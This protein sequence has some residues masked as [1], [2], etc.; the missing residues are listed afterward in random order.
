MG[1]SRQATLAEI[2]K[3]YRKLALKYHPDR[4]KSPEAQEKF[5]Q[6]NAAY[7]ILSDDQKRRQYDT[8]GSTGSNSGFNNFSGFDFSGF[9]FS[10]P[11]DIF[12]QFFSGF[13]NSFYRQQ[14]L[15]RAVAKISLE[16]VLKG[17]KKRVVIGGKETRVE[18]PPGVDNGTTFQFK[19]FLLEIEVKKHPRF[20][21][22]GRDL[23]YSIIIPLSTA[24]LGGQVEILLLEGKKVK[25]KIQPG[26]KTG[27]MVRLR[28]FGL[29]ALGRPNLR[30][31]LYVRF[32]IKMP[33][34]L[35]NDQKKLI[36]SLKK[37]GL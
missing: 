10:D 12:N 6:I 8:F 27:S 16:E 13:G 7:E 11:F 4:N 33:V 9:D 30:G 28:G 32:E 1:V 22:Q 29:P 18:I 31:D 37:T 24:I 20:Q 36:E 26:T 17:T 23:I 15:T 19:N 21:R 34:K 2:K 35:T 14:R 5:K 3:A 25:I